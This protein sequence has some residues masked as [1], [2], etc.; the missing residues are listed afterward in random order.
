MA[1]SVVL[2]RPDKKRVRWW[3]VV[4]CVII[5]LI[6]ASLLGFA[7]IG[8]GIEIQ[9]AWSGQTDANRGWA[10]QNGQGVPKDLG[11]AAELYQKAADKGYDLAQNNLGWLY[12]NGEGVPKDLGK[13][14]ELYQ[15]A[16]D[17]GNTFAQN[18][19]GWLYENGQGVPKDLGKAVE[20][21]QRAANQGYQ[22]AIANLKRVSGH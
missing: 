3:I 12:E 1:A 17:K 16:A 10:Y 15:K 20:L 21:Y 5:G 14:V 6:T 11:K 4:L 8:V 19:L 9:R 22:P 2:V 18:N 7:F 13:A